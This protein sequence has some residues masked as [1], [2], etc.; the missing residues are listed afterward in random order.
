VGRGKP[1]GLGRAPETIGLPANAVFD[2][3]SSGVRPPRKPRR[4]FRIVPFA[5]ELQFALNMVFPGKEYGQP[6]PKLERLK[7]PF[8]FSV[9]LFGT[10]FA[11]FDQ[12]NDSAAF[13]S[14]YV[15]FG[16]GAEFSADFLAVPWRLPMQNDAFPC[17]SL[18]FDGVGEFCFTWLQ[19][20]GVAIGCDL[21]RRF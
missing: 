15:A 7:E 3:T 16:E 17:I 5:E 13:K 9:E 18:Q 1:A 2:Q 19:L 6:L 20:L 21:L 8:A 14:G 4:P 11:V 12:I 10:V